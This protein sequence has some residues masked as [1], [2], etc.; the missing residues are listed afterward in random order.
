MCRNIENVKGE[1]LI[2]ISLMLSHFYVCNGLTK[3]TCLV[4]FIYTLY[5]SIQPIFFLWMTLVN[6]NQ[7]KNLKTIN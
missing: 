2:I 1:K 4:T 7:I 3:Y 5:M 6:N